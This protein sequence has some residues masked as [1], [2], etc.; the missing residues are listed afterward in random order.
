MNTWCSHDS[1][2][3]NPEKTK[4]LVLGLPQLTSQLP[5]IS[6]TVLGETLSPV[7]VA[8]DLGVYL[9]QCLNYNIHITKSASTCFLQ[10]VQV[11]G[12]KRLLH[13]KSLLLLINSFVFSKLF[14]CSSVW[15]NR[16]K[17]NINQLQ[18]AKNFAPRIVFLAKEICTC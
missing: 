9:D 15:G 6:L 14:Y 13:I 1:L 4:L 7:L 16:V 8:K 17:S 12:V 2:L 10:L 5:A 3:I 18:L 11:N